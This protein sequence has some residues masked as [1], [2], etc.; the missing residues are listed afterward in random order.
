VDVFK[1]LAGLAS[2]SEISLAK[3]ENISGYGEE[4]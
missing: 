3:S 2:S 4:K 1:S